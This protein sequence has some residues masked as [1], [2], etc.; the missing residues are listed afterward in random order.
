[1]SYDL[2]LFTTGK[3]EL[4]PPSTS[5]TCNVRIDGPDR[6]EDEDLPSNY[7]PV[8]GKKRLLY[9]IHLEGELSQTDQETVDSWLGEIV[10]QTKGV[11]I[12][13]QTEYFETLTNS[14]QLE[15]ST[16]K[17][18]KNGWMTLYFEDG[19]RFFKSGFVAMLD[20][21]SLSMPEAAPTRF[22]YYEPLQGRIEHG[23]FS[24]LLS[25]FANDPYVFL[26][27]Q[28]P[29][30]HVFL[31]IPCKKT[32]EHYH[33]QHFVRRRFLL[34]NVSFEI[35]PKLFSNQLMLKRLLKFFE[36]LCVSLDVT[37][38]EII[39]TD[40]MS[41]W[42]WYGL[43]DNQPHTICLGSAYQG[44]WPEALKAGYKIGAHHHLVTT[45]RFGNKPPRPPRELVAPSQE[46]VNPRGKPNF[47]PEFPFDYK[48]DHGKYIW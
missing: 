27:S 19:E 28:T 41:S 26:K 35:R 10:A 46:D 21:I 45:D 6:A 36:R 34:A 1:M 43:P 16:A 48:F 18:N 15:P 4:D 13:L 25:A 9:R 24:E 17:P 2:E 30:G 38:A 40:Q 20:E 5:A 42:F 8:L 37:Y 39:Q 3:H 22:G 31:N 23:D 44:V 7:L 11:L 33:P 29:F 14:G 12:D 47:A 32:F